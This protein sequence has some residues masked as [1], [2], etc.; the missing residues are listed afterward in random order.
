MSW[1][2]A[3]LLVH[4]LATTGGYVGLIAAN[5]WLLASCRDGDP[6][7]IRSAAGTWQRLARIFGPLLGLGA[8]IGFGVAAGA[9]IPLMTHWLLL[10]YAI[11]VLA[12]GGQAGLM[13][14]WQLRIEP[15]LARGER[16]AT[17]PIGLAIAVLSVAYACIVALM[18]L[19]PA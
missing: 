10:T 9:Q 17:H 3:I 6:A 7:V 12:M 11:I 16:V 5:A 19:K 15:T 2:G 8:L 18:L 1:F 13:I 4:V 14:P